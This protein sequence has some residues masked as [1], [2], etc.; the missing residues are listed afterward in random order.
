MKMKVFL[1]II[2]L[3]ILVTF[4]TNRCLIASAKLNRS[5]IKEDKILQSVMRDL[6]AG[7]KLIKNHGNYWIEFRLNGRRFLYCGKLHNTCITELV[8]RIAIGI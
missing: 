6:P 1:L 4:F 5:E 2:F 8:N 3:V 7:A